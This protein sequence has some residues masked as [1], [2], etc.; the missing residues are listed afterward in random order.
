MSGRT[1]FTDTDAGTVFT[2]TD[3]VTVFTNTDPGTVFTDT[4]PGTVFTDWVQRIDAASDETVR[5]C[6]CLTM[7]LSANTDCGACHGKD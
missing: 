1:V 5:V 7:A 3:P 2:D 6:W 4:D